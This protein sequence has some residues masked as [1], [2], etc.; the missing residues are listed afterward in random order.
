LYNDINIERIRLSE[1]WFIDATL[2]KHKEFNQLLILNYINL[3]TKEKIP[4]IY[5]LTN[6]KIQEIYESILKSIY[7]IIS[8]NDSLDVNKKL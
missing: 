8:Q 3:L 4:G 6:S 7:N 2:Y 5:A 1:N